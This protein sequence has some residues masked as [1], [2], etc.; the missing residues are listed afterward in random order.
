[1]LTTYRAIWYIQINT[2]TLAHQTFV[3]IKAHLLVIYI[4][5]MCKVNRTEI[6]VLFMSNY[7]TAVWQSRVVSLKNNGKNYKPFL[8]AKLSY[9]FYIYFCFQWRILKTVTYVFILSFDLSFGF[10]FYIS[11]LQVIQ[12]TY[13][14]NVYQSC[15][16]IT[17]VGEVYA[18]CW[19]ICVRH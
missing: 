15:S 9:F 19:T 6:P 16:S 14:L 7:V 3:V 11:G 13:G 2:C 17:W 5:T 1:M 10:F 12:L 4:I 18:L 8:D